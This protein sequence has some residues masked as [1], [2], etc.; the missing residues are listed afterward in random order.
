M[1][2]ALPAEV[3]VLILG[4][5][6]HLS[7]P[8]LKWLLDER[9]DVQ[10]KHVRLADK[11]LV[12][13]G[14]STTYVDPDTWTALKDPRVE[15]RQVNLNI[16]TNLSKVYDHPQGG[17][18]DIVFDFTGEGIDHQDVPEE[19]LLER[20]AKLA[21]SIASE[22]LRRGVKAHV[23]ETFA[24]LTVEANAPAVKESDVIKPSSARAYWWYE[25]ERAAASVD[26]LPLAIMRSAEV[27]GPFISSGSILSRYGLGTLYKRLGE[28]LK[29]LW[30]PE[31]RIHTIHIDDWCPAAWQ[32]VRWVASRSRS[33]ADQLAGENLPPVRIKDKVQ[34]SLREKVGPECC[35]RTQTPRAPVFNLV[36]DTNLTQGKLLSMTGEAFQVE[37]GFVNALVNAYARLNLAGVAEDIN[38][39]HMNAI[40]E[41][42]KETG[43]QTC[44]VKGWLE[45]ELLANRS[46]AFD[47]AKIKR[48][49]GW[50]PKI[51]I[52]RKCLDEILDKL[53]ALNQFPDP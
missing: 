51:Q 37:T 2:Q 45:T 40:N 44:P 42:I 13:N 25:A 14:T 17:S 7:R 23:R 33:E 43:I 15:Y 52:D 38:E 20:T 41:I 36:D 16:A 9:A 4:G 35:P 53:R 12:S 30:G 21:R 18:Y 48:V 32:V 46:L 6:A 49:L 10:I 28:P 34:D 39:K 22:S 19:L 8:L 29:L 47:N 26:H 3:S 27:V 11:Y 50:S 1:S 5:T 31:L 24:F